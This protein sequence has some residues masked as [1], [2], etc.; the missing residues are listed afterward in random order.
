MVRVSMWTI[1]DAREAHRG[2]PAL[3]YMVRKVF[4]GVGVWCL[5]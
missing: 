3:V 2:A 1:L 5:R 4:W